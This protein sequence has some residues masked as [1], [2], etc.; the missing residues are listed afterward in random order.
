VKLLLSIILSFLSINLHAAFSFSDDFE[1]GNTS[2][3]DSTIPRAAI[4]GPGCS[5]NLSVNNSAASSGVFGLEAVIC[6]TSSGIAVVEDSNPNNGPE[7]ELNYRAAFNFNH[8]NAVISNQQELVIFQAR[9]NPSSSIVLELRLY[10]NNME[11]EIRAYTVDDSGAILGP[12]SIPLPDLV[13][14]SGTGSNANRIGVG[15]I[16]ASGPGDNNGTLT[17]ALNQGNDTPPVNLTGIDNDTKLVHRIRMGIIESSGNSG[18][19]Y[20]DNYKSNSGLL[21]VTLMQF[22]VD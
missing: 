17:L 1:N 21:P 11:Y 14:E 18:F 20:F 13:T 5:A 10:R 16:A 6:D 3:W 4:A 2:A 22:E 9:S 8:I 19:V 15:Y 7:D 12:I